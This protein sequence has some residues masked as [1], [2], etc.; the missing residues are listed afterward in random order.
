M[1]ELLEPWV[2]YIPLNEDFSDVEEKMQWILDNDEQ[3][4]L[5]A[6][7]GSSWIYDLVLHPEAANDDKQIQDEIIRRYRAHFVAA[8]S[9]VANNGSSSKKHLSETLI[10]NK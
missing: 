5:I 6:Q 8:D 1:E 10:T 4:Q 2:H 7:R 9:P 3:A